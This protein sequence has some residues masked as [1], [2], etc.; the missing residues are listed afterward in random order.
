MQVLC[1]LAEFSCLAETLIRKQIICRQPD[2]LRVGEPVQVAA[3]TAAAAA[4]DAG[5]PAASVVMVTVHSIRPAEPR[6]GAGRFPQAGAERRRAH[7]Y[8]VATPGCNCVGCFRVGTVFENVKFGKTR[9]LLQD[10]KVWRKCHYW[11][12]S[13]KVLVYYKIYLV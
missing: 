9:R 4:V 13:C 5:C 10:W 3:S 7:R 8:R 12:R 6:P 11:P 1:I 2:D